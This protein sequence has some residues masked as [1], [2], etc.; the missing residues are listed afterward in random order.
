MNKKDM[1]KYI[2]S[3]NIN[4]EIKAFLLL[5]LGTG[6][7]IE[8]ILRLKIKDLWLLRSTDFLSLKEYPFCIDMRQ[9]SLIPY[10][11]QDEEKPLFSVSVERIQDSL[12]YL[13][14]SPEML[15]KWTAN[16]FYNNAL[17]EFKKNDPKMLKGLPDDFFNSYAL[18]YLSELMG[19]TLEEYRDLLD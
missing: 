6:R 8:T 1:Q 13:G 15:K 4:P 14:I 18:K 9:D 16:K 19:L 10:V 5:M 3:S 7:D 2:E 17:E 11:N 12:D